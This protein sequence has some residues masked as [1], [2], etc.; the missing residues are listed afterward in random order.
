MN[1]SIKLVVFDIAGTTVK[2]NGEIATAFHDAMK[3]KGYDIPHEK[4]YPLM[5]YKKTEAIRMILQEYESDVAGITAEYINY[6]HDRFVELM[7]EYYTH[8]DQLQ[9]LPHA[10]EMFA[11]LRA[12][13]IK[14]GLDTGFSTQITNV[15]IDRLGWLKDGK[16]DY[17]I[18]SNEVPAGRPHPYMI[19]KMME[20]AGIA[21]PKQ[22]IKIGDTEVD[23]NEGKNAG[24]LYSIAITTGAFTREALQPYT[25]DFIIDDLQ[26]LVEIISE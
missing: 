2:D 14:V 4:I 21:D 5:G 23:I 17:V 8:T 7:V 12:R 25:P 15:I 13:G 10:E 26:E 19:Q 22:V 24:C 20:A 6:I 11:W 1:N 3:E 9:P 18:C 16:V